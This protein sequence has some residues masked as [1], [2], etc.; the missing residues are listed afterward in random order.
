MEASKEGEVP[1]EPAPEELP[2]DIGEERPKKKMLLAVVVAVIVVI[3][4]IAAAIGLGLFGGDEEPEENVPP[5]A[6]ARATSGRLLV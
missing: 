3:A 4:A 2:S 6:G 5:T 1:G